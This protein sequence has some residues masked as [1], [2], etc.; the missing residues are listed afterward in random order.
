MSKGLRTRVAGAL[1]SR[2]ILRPYGITT[3]A[4]VYC[5]ELFGKALANSST[6]LVAASRVLNVKRSRA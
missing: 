1:R 4:T 6:H 3:Y 5:T 2:N